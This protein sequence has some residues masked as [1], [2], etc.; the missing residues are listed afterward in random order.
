MMRDWVEA[1]SDEQK[2]VRQTLEKL[3]DAIKKREMS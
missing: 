3:A 2:R 1:Q